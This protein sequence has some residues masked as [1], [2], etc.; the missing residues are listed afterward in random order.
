MKPRILPLLLAGLF[1]PAAA[2]ADDP[3]APW[4]SE[5]SV[6]VGGIG[7]NKSG[8]DPSKVEEYQDL[9]S[10]IL[11]NVF[12]RG[13]NDKTWFD[14]YGENFGR[15]DMFVAL[16]GGQYE[17]FSYSFVSNWLPHTFADPALTP[18]N[19]SGT[20]L[21]TPSTPFPNTNVATWNR[22]N[23]GYER[24]DTHGHFEWKTNTPWYTRV[25][26]GQL[27]FSGTR[28]GSGAL[29]TS[30][31]NG[32]MDLAIPVEYKTNTATAELGYTQPTRHFAVSYTYS[33]F[34]NGNSTLNWTNPFFGS[35]LDTTFLPAD[36]T[37]QRIAA[38]GV[39]RSLPYGSTLAARYTWSKTTNETTA[40]STVLT[41]GSGGSGTGSFV[42]T[43]P[44][45][46]TF[47]GEL[48]DQTI[49]LALTSSP[50]KTVDTRV[51][52]NYHK[53]ENNSTAVTFA[54]GT[55]V[56]CNGPCTSTLYDYRKSNFG[57]DGTWRFARGN[58]FAAGWDYLETTQNRV[59]FDHVRDNKLW[60]EWKTTAFEDVTARA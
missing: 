16:R 51:Y 39:M 28:P 6:T 32:F 14:F 54:E 45:R 7:T 57:L 2:L 40:A 20:S 50:T 24:K 60:L 41:S 46:D 10:G 19:G 22:I 30:P 18:F 55:A 17:R 23:L 26:G 47:N 27:S 9:S 42:P 29:G 56:D 15:D 35:N 58:R 53:L 38:N 3:P 44:N 33:K 5:G 49:A 21:L 52:Y 8:S 48:V 43:M 59:D 13:R 34:D 31:G 11:S 36:N 4:I 12:S 1:A 25:E 37:Y